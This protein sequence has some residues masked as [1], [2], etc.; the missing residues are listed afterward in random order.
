[1]GQYIS[2]AGS[3]DRHGGILFYHSTGH[4]DN[5]PD[6]SSDLQNVDRNIVGIVPTVSAEDESMIG[7]RINFLNVS[8]VI[9]YAAYS[10]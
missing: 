6:I 9:V 3:D 10:M 4:D 1:M 8:P 5:P 7:N 2:L